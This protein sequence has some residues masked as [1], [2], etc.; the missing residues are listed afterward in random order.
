[1]SQAATIEDGG[2]EEKVVMV[3]DVARAFF[4]A[5][6]TRPICIELQEEDKTQE[7]GSETG[8]PV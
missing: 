6:A 8:S 4:G 1:M 2:K 3:N 7:G 5:G